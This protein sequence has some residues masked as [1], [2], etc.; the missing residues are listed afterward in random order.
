[1]EEREMTEQNNQQK[2]QLGQMKTM[3]QVN[4]QLDLA[5]KAGWNVL[6]P[7]TLIIGESDQCAI[8]LEKTE[9]STD[10]EDG[11]IYEDD[12]K[13]EATNKSGIENESK[14]YRLHK[15]ALMRLARLG[16]LKWW[17]NHSRI[18]KFEKNYISYQ[19]VASILYP[20]GQEVPWIGNDD[21]D[22]LVLEE[23][24]REQYVSKSKKQEKWEE[25]EGGGK[26]RTRPATEEEKA[27]YVNYCTKRDL[28]QKR[29]HKLAIVETGA[30]ERVIRG[31]LGLKNSYSL[32]QLKMPFLVARIVFRPDYSNPNVFRN[33]ITGGH[34]A[35]KSLYGYAPPVAE[36]PETCS[37]PEEKPGPGNGNPPP[38]Q[39]APPADPPKQEPDGFEKLDLTGKIKKIELL[40]KEVQYD[41]ADY[42]KRG[43]WK[44][45]GSLS[46]STLSSLYAFLEKTK[47]KKESDI[48]F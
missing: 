6:V 46:N 7:S 38:T 36:T 24:Y 2:I 43:K 31:A 45:I 34:Q 10:P 5:R 25:P 17:P 20:D 1:M 41:L 27:E 33:A 8:V 13:E 26:R 28:L 48:P 44:D 39:A 12:Y 42:L 30:M 23:K 3:E 22:F 21:L 11:E 14:R 4:E 29:E 35:I 37:K 19:A 32:K 47:K 15:I 40:S 16:G 18:D 9:I